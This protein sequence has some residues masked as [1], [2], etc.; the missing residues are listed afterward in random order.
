MNFCAA[1]PRLNSPVS[2]LQAINGPLG[3]ERDDILFAQLCAVGQLSETRRAVGQTETS[4]PNGSGP[5]VNGNVAATS[6]AA[7][8]AARWDRQ[9]QTSDD[10]RVTC[11]HPQELIIKIGADTVR[12]DKIDQAASS[13]TRI[14]ARCPQHRRKLSGTGKLDVD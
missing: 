12:I 14:L 9:Q 2:G 13:S 10:T 7:L 8:N 4:F 1:H 3:P 11:G 6:V 5:E